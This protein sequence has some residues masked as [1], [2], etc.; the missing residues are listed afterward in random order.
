MNSSFRDLQNLD[1]FVDLPDLEDL[2]LKNNGILNITDIDTKFPNLTVLDISHNK[3]FSIENV[4]IL[5]NL[6]CIAE[7]NFS[8]NPICVHKQ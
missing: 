1:N 3:I 8:H 7:V 4:E 5:H 6:P 2:S